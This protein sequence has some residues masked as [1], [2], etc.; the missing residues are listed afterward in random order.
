MK[1]MNGMIALGGVCWRN[2]YVSSHLKRREN[3][4]YNTQYRRDKNRRNN[5]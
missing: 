2:F 3:E 4:Y 5:I 1:L